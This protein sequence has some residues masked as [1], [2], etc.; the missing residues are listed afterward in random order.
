MEYFKIIISR[1]ISL[2]CSLS[3]DPNNTDL[4]Q[5]Y[6]P[7]IPR[8]ILLLLIYSFTFTSAFMQWM[9]KNNWRVTGR[10]VWVKKSPPWGVLTFFFFFHKQLRIFNRFFTHLLYVPIYARLQIFIQLSPI[11]KKLCHIKHDYPVSHNMLKMF[12]IGRKACVDTFA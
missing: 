10:T 6:H 5:V 2:G 4:L 9:Q 8:D 3:A 11:L 7:E 1:L 12:T